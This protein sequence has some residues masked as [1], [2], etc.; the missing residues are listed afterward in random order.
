[1]LPIF[2]VVAIL[3]LAPPLDRDPNRSVLNMTLKVL[4][5]APRVFEIP[6]FLSQLEVNHII[7]LASGIQLKLSGTGDIGSDSTDSVEMDEISGTRTSYNSWV[8]REKSPIVDAIYR[9]AADLM[10]IDERLLRARTEEESS[11]LDG[12][13]DPLCEELQL[14]HYDKTQEYTEH[15]D[16]GFSSI[17][18]LYQGTRFGTLLLYLNSDVV[19]G[20]TSFPRWANAETFDELKVTPEAGKA[21]LFY[22]QLPDGNLDDFSQHAAKPVISGEKWVRGDDDILEY[23]I[24]NSHFSRNCFFFD[25]CTLSANNALFAILLQLINLWTWDPRNEY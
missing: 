25:L 15:H 20:E 7:E 17:D 8:P 12:Y 10:R 2:P 13:T 19:G 16:F 1:V 21:V 18:D 9:R 14:V 24:D 11:D 6:N 22:S 23:S 4:S 3:V 5:C